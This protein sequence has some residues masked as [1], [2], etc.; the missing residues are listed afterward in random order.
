MQ[1]GRQAEIRD[2]IRDTEESSG[3]EKKRRREDE[4]RVE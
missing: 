2:D 1:A 3:R 4:E